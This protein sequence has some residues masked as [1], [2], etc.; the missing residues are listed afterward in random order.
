MTSEII[1]SKSGSLFLE[2]APALLPEQVKRFTMESLRAKPVRSF[3]AR[4]SLGRLR[5]HDGKT[6]IAVDIGGDKISASFFTVGDGILRSSSNI[7]TRHGDDGAGYL[8]ALHELRE[9]ARTRNLPVDRKSV[10]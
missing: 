7:L 9:L 1:F 5:N 8:D 2:E 6:V 3:D 4:R 10:V